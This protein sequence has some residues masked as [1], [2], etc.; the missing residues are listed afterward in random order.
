[1][2]FDRP[3]TPRFRDGTLDC[4]EIQPQGAHESLQ[5]INVG[6]LRARQPVMEGRDLPVSQDGG[7]P[8]RHGI[9]RA[10]RQDIH[11]APPLQIHEDGTVVMLPLLSGPIINADD[12]QDVRREWCRGRPLQTAQNG[13]ITD[14]HA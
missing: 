8:R 9:G 10:H 3:I 6:G 5:R 7:E 4:T 11:D 12:A 14:P 1:V 13:V 2:S